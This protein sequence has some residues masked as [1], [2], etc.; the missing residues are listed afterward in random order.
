MERKTKRLGPVYAP[1]GTLVAFATSPGQFASDGV[2]RNG[3]YTDALL[4][5][6]EEPD[7]P[8]EAMFKRVRNTLGAATN[9]KQISWEHTSLA[10]EFYFKISTSTSIENYSKNA[11]ADRLFVL[12]E[13]KFSHRAIRALKTYNWYKQ[14]PAIESLSLERLNAAGSDSLFVLGRNILQAA[15]GSANAAAQFI[16]NFR[17]TTGGM[18][19]A[20]RKALLDGIIFEIFFNSEGELRKRPKLNFFNEAFALEE[21]DEFQESFKFISGA[22]AREAQRMFAIPGRGKIVTADIR[23]V[24]DNV[25]DGVFIGGKNYLVE[26]GDSFEL[27]DVSVKTFQTLDRSDF[28]NE[29]SQRMLVP[30]RLLKLVYS[31]PVDGLISVKIPLGAEIARPG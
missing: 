21:F 5:H 24:G 13:A 29:L 14:N 18:K 28:E 6:I 23:I 17:A 12:D 1:R 3:Q 8:V 4:K 26:E 25:V 2:G 22:L 16:V 30:S 20:K 27:D 9:Q 15:H 7:L 11:I 31:K 19:S 10:G